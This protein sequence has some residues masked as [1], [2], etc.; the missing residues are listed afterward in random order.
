MILY[1]LP[2]HWRA[3]A[4]DLERYSP[5]AAQAFREAAD[6]LDELLQSVGASV[7][8]KEASTLGGYSI[9]ALQRM[10]ASGRVE[11]AG[12]KGRPRIRRADVP[13]KPGHSYELSKRAPPVMVSPTAVV[14]SAIAREKRP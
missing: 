14:A 7:T 9:D 4:T 11:N 8:L 13:T 2:A 1:G 12:R 10:V 5:A 6:Q 3:R